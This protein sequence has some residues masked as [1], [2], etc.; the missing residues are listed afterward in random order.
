MVKQKKESEKKFKFSELFQQSI[1]D[2][3]SNFKPI[4][5]LVLI[6]IGIILVL[7]FL[8][9][10]IVL[11]T[12]E[13]VFSVMSDPVLISQYNQGLI[14][15]PLY[16]NI[17]SSIFNI[18]YLFLALF[19]SVSLIA[20]SVKK[21]R[22]SYKEIIESGKSNYWRYFGLVVV[23]AIFSLLLFLLLIIPGIIFVVY[24]TFAAYVF[25]DK[26][27][28]IMAS[29]KESRKIVKGRWWKTLGY[30]LLLGLVVLAIIIVASIIRLPTAIPLML[31]TI[32]SANISLG[33]LLGSLTVDLIYQ[34]IITLIVTPLSV[35]FLKNFYLEMKKSV[36]ESPEKKA[37]ETK[38]E[39][40]SS[41]KGKNKN[42]FIKKK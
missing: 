36:K 39:A 37:K 29:L 12:D 24:W 8:F 1:E 3:K 34:I 41:K 30:L 38:K 13:R 19:V 35:F 15:F 14:D 42:K 2:Y 25:L 7:A 32:S 9:N 18:I 23:T 4:L 26:K 5:K 20:V 21:Q 17:I 40:K 22:F 31:K 33:L 28:K 16:Y 11:I 27:Q 10:S 6:F